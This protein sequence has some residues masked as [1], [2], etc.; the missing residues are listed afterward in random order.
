MLQT[1]RYMKF[2]RLPYMN[3]S[4]PSV[5]AILYIYRVILNLGNVYTCGYIIYYGQMNRRFHSGYN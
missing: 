4:N 1:T 2:R 3:S 5:N